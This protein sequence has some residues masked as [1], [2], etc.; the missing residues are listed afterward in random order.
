MTNTIIDEIAT[1]LAKG[2]L[3]SRHKERLHQPGSEKPAAGLAFPAEP[4]VHVG[5]A[6]AARKGN[7]LGH[8]RI[9]GN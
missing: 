5:G 8:H 3:K 6:P 2:F 1:V 4:S 9:K 7:E